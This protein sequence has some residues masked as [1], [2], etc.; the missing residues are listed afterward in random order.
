V[1]ADEKG[2][3]AALAALP[4]LGPKSGA[5]LYAAGIRDRDTLQSLGPVAAWFAVAD[6]GAKPSLNL[7]WAIAGALL[8]VHWTKIPD[9]YRTSLLMEY[10]AACELR[11]ARGA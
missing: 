7:L 9:D 2:L 1:P 10:D 5:M 6:N 4:N 8:D 11:K 3:R